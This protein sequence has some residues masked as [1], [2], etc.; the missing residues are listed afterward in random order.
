LTSLMSPC[1]GSFRP[2]PYRD[3]AS[4]PLMCCLLYLPVSVVSQTSPL[5]LMTVYPFSSD[6]L[7]YLIAS[8][9]VWLCCKT[10]RPL[11]V[12]PPPP[13][14][15]SRFPFIRHPRWV[16]LL[17]KSTTC[18]YI[19][20]FLVFHPVVSVLSLRNPTSLPPA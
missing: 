14:V 6:P 5:S 9:R 1:Q 3:F 4:F 10:R 20:F 19:F 17:P 13:L 8:F 16:L 12:L 15:F 7:F 2:F 11:R 18:L